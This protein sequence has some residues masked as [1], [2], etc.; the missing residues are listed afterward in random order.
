MA[1]PLSPL[2]PF[3]GPAIK[4]RTFFCVFPKQKSIKLKQIF[5]N[6]NVFPDPHLEGKIK[7]FICIKSLVDIALRYVR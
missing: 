4:R 6:Q 2:A 1:C 5:T 7:S 3:N